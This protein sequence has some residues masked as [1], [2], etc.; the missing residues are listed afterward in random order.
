MTY[1]I[2]DTN[3]FT[4]EVE[5]VSADYEQEMLL[6]YSD[7]SDPDQEDDFREYAEKAVKAKFGVNAILVWE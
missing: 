3:E 2:Y 6:S 5:I 7:Y 1:H 4:Q